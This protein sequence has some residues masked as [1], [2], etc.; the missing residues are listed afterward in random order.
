L[1]IKISKYQ[2]STFAGILAILFW[3]SNVAFSKSVLETEGTY[4][5]AFYI[6]F[7]SGILNF[8]ILYFA[9]GKKDF[10]KKIRSLPFSYYYKTG[11]FFI[12]NNI[13]LFIAIGLTKNNKELIIVTILNY[14][15][16][17]LIYILKI[18]IFKEKPKPLIFA[19]GLL[20]VVT[21]LFFVFFQEY[22]FSEI[23]EML[24]FTNTNIWAYFFAFLTAFSWAIY[25]N[26]IKKYNTNDDIIAIP[27][28]FTFT[29]IIFAFVQLF[30]QRIDT[31]DFTVLYKNTDL[32]ITIIAPTS[33]GYLFWYF[34]IKFGNKKLIT[35]LSYFIPVISILLISYI[36]SF[37]IEPIFWIG[38]LLTVLGAILSY[39]SFN[40][41]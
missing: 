39:K 2:L 37:K 32:L 13:L 34:G 18:P 31:L 23:I 24:K 12:L 14:L 4:N 3:G 15:W 30:N 36:Y 35:S 10:I 29:G 7:F 20:S 5:G 1:K 38:T 40:V 33:L 25:S 41:N 26:L 8:V 16:P 11:I 21:G 17:V 28:I 9:L 19:T 6:Y 22:S 27:F